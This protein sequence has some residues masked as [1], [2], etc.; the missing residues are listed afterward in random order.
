MAKEIVSA[1][2]PLAS[3]IIPFYNRLRLVNFA[4]Q[5]VL[6]QSYKNLEIIL[7]DDGSTE[8]IDLSAYQNDKRVVYIYQ[9]NSGPAR[10]R[11]LGV[12]QARGEYVFF[13]DSD[14]LFTPEKIEKQI[15]LMVKHCA[16]FSHTNYFLISSDKKINSQI[17]TSHCSGNVFPRIILRCPIATP[18]VCLRAD[19]ARNFKFD[20]TLRIGEDV[21]LWTKIAQRY[22]ILAIDEPLTYV[23]MHAH[24]TAFDFKNKFANDLGVLKR[25]MKVKNVS[26]LYCYMRLL[27]IYGLRFFSYTERGNKVGNKVA[28]KK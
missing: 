5:S 10:A 19:I 12:S 25:I 3:V 21:V 20:E 26:R 15:T 23:R 22:E 1:H 17:K 13:L 7:V 14:D 4:V 28:R 24:S 11:N 6:N 2:S 16:V 9:S 18:T 27:I 8:K